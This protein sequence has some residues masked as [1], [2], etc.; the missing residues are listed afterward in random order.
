MK[1]E[2]WEA[3]QPTWFR[4]GRCSGEVSLDE[5]KIIFY[6]KIAWRREGLPVFL[7]V[8]ILGDTAIVKHGKMWYAALKTKCFEDIEVND[9]K[10][11]NQELQNTLWYAGLDPGTSEGCL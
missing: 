6:R 4:K 11:K 2:M 1:L 8:I 5:A 9:K 3:A 7:L 10:K